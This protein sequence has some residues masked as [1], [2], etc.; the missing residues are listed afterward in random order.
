MLK[1][2]KIK[3][4]GMLFEGERNLWVRNQSNSWSNILLSFSHSYLLLQCHFKEFA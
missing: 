3:G 4:H 2:H 1:T